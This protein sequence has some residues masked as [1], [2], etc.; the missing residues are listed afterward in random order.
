[1]IGKGKNIV[2]EVIVIC[3]GN[4]EDRH[5]NVEVKCVITDVMR[6]IFSCWAVENDEICEEYSFKGIV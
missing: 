1:M 6:W 2:C 3:L 4:N 5:V